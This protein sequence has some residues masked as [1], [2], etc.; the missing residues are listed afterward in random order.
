MVLAP[1]DTGSLRGVRLRFSAVNDKQGLSDSRAHTPHL[2]SSL[3]VIMSK[4]TDTIIFCNVATSM[5]VLK[6]FNRHEGL[7]HPRR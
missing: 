7:S 1:R 6:E 4:V 5:Q 2:C 3:D